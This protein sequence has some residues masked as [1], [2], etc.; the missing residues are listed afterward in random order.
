MEQ[1]F[2]EF[3]RSQKQVDPTNEMVDLFLGIMQEE[4]GE[5]NETTTA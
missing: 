4:K 5:E 2:C 1:L 3:Y